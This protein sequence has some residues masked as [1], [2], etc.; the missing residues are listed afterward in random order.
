MPAIFVQ[1]EEFSKRAGDEAVAKL[2]PKRFIFCRKSVW[3]QKTA[4][5]SSIGR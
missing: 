4:L 1:L 3:T 5:S 2:P